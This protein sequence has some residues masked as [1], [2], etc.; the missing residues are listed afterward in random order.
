MK[1]CKNF[2]GDEMK[3]FLLILISVAT[4][5]TS[6]CSSSNDKTAP[7]FAGVQTLE[8]AGTTSVILSWDPA[9][10]DV[11]SSSDIRYLVY[12]SLSSGGQNFTKY[13][14]RTD[15]GAASVEITDL[16]VNT[17]YY[18]VVRAED[19]A[20]NEDGNTVELSGHALAPVLLEPSNVAPTSMDINWDAY[21]KQDFASYRLHRGI[22]EGFIP[23]DAN[24]LGSWSDPNLTSYSDT[25]LESGKTYYYRLV[26]V[27]TSTP[28][29]K[30]VKSNEVRATA[31]DS[32]LVY[33]P[34]STNIVWGKGNSPVT[35]TGDV[36]ITSSG[37]LT[38]DPGVTVKS[39]VPDQHDLGLD[40]ARIAFIVNGTLVASG[41]SSENINLTSAAASPAAGNWWGI[42]MNGSSSNN[43]VLRYVN[44]QYSDNGIQIQGASPS[45][46]NVILTNNGQ[47]SNVRVF[48][49]FGGSKATIS[50][51]V[52]RNSSKTGFY[53][54][55]YTGSATNLLSEN[56]DIGFQINDANNIAISGLHSTNCR[57][58]LRI[59]SGSSS[60][61]ATVSNSIFENSTETGIYIEEG[62]GIIQ[63]C[64][65]LSSAGD[66]IYI[67]QNFDGSEGGAL[68]LNHSTISASGGYGIHCGG[69]PA[70]T[71][72]AYI[73]NS[74]ITG[75][76]QYGVFS[77]SGSYDVRLTDIYFA[78]NNG[79][80]A[81]VAD[82]SFTIPNS[83]SVPKQYFNVDSVIAPRITPLDL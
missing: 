2:Y 60:M 59:S 15:K 47:S 67:D 45:V 19:S 83:S 31:M 55:N 76:S 61:V 43:S 56:A 21:D 28:D 6:S 62:I 9:T 7:V 36:Q 50:D 51:C 80:T 79:A 48:A 34:I 78:G 1:S 75:S 70:V 66:G 44:I 14:L 22:E 57:E 77:E 72:E 71:R 26:M 16:E 38:I 35:L 24:I 64:Q 49:A 68:N 3:S 53:F 42:R 5:I 82:T 40:S 73:W 20:G 54:E 13:N 10:D 32:L 52:V 65:I 8:G 63:N 58:G 18:F 74:N 11:T 12:Y 30:L 69:N 46:S 27:N 41:T 23:S 17:T 37:K 39:S 29:A 81:G 33:G 25:D 4:V